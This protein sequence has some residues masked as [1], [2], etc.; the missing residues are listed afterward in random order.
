[1]DLL[2]GESDFVDCFYYPALKTATR[3]ESGALVTLDGPEAHHAVHVL[4]M[5]SGQSLELFDGAG[6][7][8][9]GVVRDV[10]K[11]ALAIEIGTVEHV[12]AAACRI[13]LATAIPKGDRFDWLVEKATELGVDELIPLVTERSVVEPRASKLDRLRAAVVAACKQSRRRHLLEIREPVSFAEFLRG[14]RSDQQAILADPHGAPWAPSRDDSAES[15]ML[16]AVGPEGGFTPGEVES[17]CQAG[18]LLRTFGASV[19]RVETA[20]VAYAAI[21]GLE[22]IRRN[23]T[24]A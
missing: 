2:A 9:T 13:M 17:A 10:G 21:A 7:W 3:R 4:R 1:M 22:R 18:F 19:L 6:G 20:G 14:P 12:P 24:T 8:T 16:C 15:S 11:R 5:R 23:H